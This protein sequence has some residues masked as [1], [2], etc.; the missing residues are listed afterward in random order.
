VTSPACW[1]STRLA[2]ESAV[3]SCLYIAAGCGWT[4]WVSEHCG[5]LCL[6]LDSQQRREPVL[7]IHRRAGSRYF[8]SIS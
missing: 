6:S 8:H 5:C 7:F 3:A 1:P 4:E 2:K